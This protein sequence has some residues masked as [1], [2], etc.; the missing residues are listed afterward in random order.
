MIA[1]ILVNFHF[2]KFQNLLEAC[3]KIQ[4]LNSSMWIQQVNWL[5]RVKIRNYLKIKLQVVLAK[6]RLIRGRGVPQPRL[7][8]QRGL[9]LDAPAD[10]VPRPRLGAHGGAGT[11]PRIMCARHAPPGCARRGGP[12]IHYDTVRT[13]R[14]STRLNSSHVVISYAVFCLKKKN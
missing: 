12:G 3:S 8:A 9:T 4:E 7:C 6:V 11:D 1:V 10:I 5:L 13:D 2:M 14:K